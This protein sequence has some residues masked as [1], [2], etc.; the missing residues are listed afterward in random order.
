MSLDRSQ[1]GTTDTGRVLE[2]GDRVERYTVESMI[3][4]GGTATVYRVRHAE[5]DNTYALK[6]LTIV[7]PAIRR[8]TL[9]E[10]RVQAQMQHRNVVAVYDVFEVEGAPALLMEYIEGPSLETA[11]TRKRFTLDQAR[12]LFRGIVD[13]VRHAHRIGLVHRD[14]KPANVLLAQTSRGILPK[15]T[16]FGIAKVVEGDQTGHTRAGVAMGTPQYMAPEQIRDAA[17][18]DKRADVFSLGCILYELVTGRRAFPY[19]DIVKVY[20][21]VCD[22]E[23]VAPRRI[24]PDLPEPIEA[25]ILGAMEIDRDRR[26]PDTDTLIAV[27]EGL[28]TWATTEGSMPDAVVQVEDTEQAEIPDQPAHT[29]LPTDLLVRGLD[30]DTDDLTTGEMQVEPAPAASPFAATLAPVTQTPPIA[31]PAAERSPASWWKGAAV[32]FSVMATLWVAWLLLMGGPTP[33]SQVAAPTDPALSAAEVASS[34]PTV[35]PAGDPADRADPAA[36]SAPSPVATPPVAATPVA[37]TPAAATPLASRPAEPTKAQEPVVAEPV[38]PKVAPVAVEPA[39]VPPPAPKPTPPPP[40]TVRITSVPLTASVYVDGAVAGR[41]P[42]KAPLPPGKH[43]VR[44]V[45]GTDSQSFQIQVE[46]GAENR[47]CFTFADRKVTKGTCA[48]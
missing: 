9:Q 23:F 1:H 25:A 6:V 28:R 10:G 35:A 46:A 37:A 44:V 42:F 8:R 30:E 15:V 43:D 17:K 27:F 11:L 34:V 48:P 36:P 38:S 18:V 16:D 39:V 4:A 21:A 7:S 45:S 19:D 5:L 13:G 32:G 40:P 41:T 12:I 20:N 31:A 14:L 29:W 2:A 33:T 24:V 47:W 22:G 3:G 26:I